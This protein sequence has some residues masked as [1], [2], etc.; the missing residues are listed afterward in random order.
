MLFSLLKHYLDFFISNTV[1]SESI[2]IFFC[3]TSSVFHGVK[4][5]FLQALGYTNLIETLLQRKNGIVIS[6]LFLGF[7]KNA[8]VAFIE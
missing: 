3:F 1:C 8:I 4:T 2:L 5:C 7:E 6:I